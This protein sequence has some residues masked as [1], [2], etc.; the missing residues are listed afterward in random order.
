MYKDT[1]RTNKNKMLNTQLGELTFIS[2]SGKCF[3]LH[4]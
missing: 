1:L 2:R 4:Q 3:Q